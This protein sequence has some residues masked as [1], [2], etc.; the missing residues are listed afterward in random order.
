MS[1]F[2]YFTILAK[3]IDDIGHGNNYD[4]YNNNGEYENLN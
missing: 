1:L 2:Q 4:N 3:K